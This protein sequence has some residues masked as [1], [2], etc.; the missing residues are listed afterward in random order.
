MIQ[1]DSGSEGVGSLEP[2]E[3]A[4]KVDAFWHQQG[5]DRGVDFVP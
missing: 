1:P 4:E 5:W 2:S 3:K